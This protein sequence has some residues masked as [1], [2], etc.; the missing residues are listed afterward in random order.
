ME[1]GLLDTQ[2]LYLN[3]LERC[4]FGVYIALFLTLHTQQFLFYFI[5]LVLRGF[6]VY[7]RSVI[8]SVLPLFILSERSVDLVIV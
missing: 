1:L 6:D 4:L 8:S 2:N 5:F 7:I 3:I